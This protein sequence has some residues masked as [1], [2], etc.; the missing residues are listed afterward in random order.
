[1]RRVKAKMLFEM[2]VILAI[3]ICIIFT[4][5][6]AFLLLKLHIIYNTIIDKTKGRVSK[7]E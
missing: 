3:V 4:V 6:F 5:R 7:D 2:F 1:M